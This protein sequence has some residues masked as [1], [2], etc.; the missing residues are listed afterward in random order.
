[1][2]GDQGAAHLGR[3]AGDKFGQRH[4]GS[5]REAGSTFR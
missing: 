2:D 5:L 4:G 1:M 3:S